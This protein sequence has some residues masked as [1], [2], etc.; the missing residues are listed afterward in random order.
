[1]VTGTISFLVRLVW[2]GWA[3]QIPDTKLHTHK[4]SQACLQ[5]YLS[6]L[7]LGVSCFALFCFLI[8]VSN[9]ICSVPG[10]FLRDLRGTVVLLDKMASHLGSISWVCPV[11]A[12]KVGSPAS[13]CVSLSE[14]EGS[15]KLL[16]PRTQQRAWSL[17]ATDS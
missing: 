6:L 8:D 13:G 16:I 17:E 11:S 9:H 1:M 4:E 10:A 2:L 3:S 12:T 15:Y 14:D 7:H 5:G